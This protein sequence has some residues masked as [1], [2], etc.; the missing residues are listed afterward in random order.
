MNRLKELRNE[1]NLTQKELG[2]LFNASQNTISQ[3]ENGSRE[4]S[5]DRLAEIANYF[6]VTIDY[7]LG[8]SG[9]RKRSFE[10]IDPMLKQLISL[11]NQMDEAGRESLLGV[12]RAMKKNK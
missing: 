10:P 1:R 2:L 5:N 8:I 9:E 6:D 11:Y 12:M 3:W 4:I 7:L